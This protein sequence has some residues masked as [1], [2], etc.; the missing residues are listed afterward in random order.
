[1]KR[2]LVPGAAVLALLA[3]AG[4]SSTSSPGV[5]QA[6]SKAQSQVTRCLDTTGITGML[7]SS[8]R[9]RFFDCVKAIAAP[10][11]QQQLENCLESAASRDQM[12]LSSGRHTFETR[13]APSCL[14]AAA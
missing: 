11:K 3:V 13:D 10:G 4:C 9:A 2:T 12:W 5:S 7:T 14:D 6:G 1:M 8:G